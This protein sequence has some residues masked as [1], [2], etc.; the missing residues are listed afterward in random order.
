MQFVENA[1]TVEDLRDD[2]IRGDGFRR[3]D[4]FRRFGSLFVD[5]FCEF[6][7]DINED[8]NEDTSRSFFVGR[9]NIV[10]EGLKAIHWQSSNEVMRER[11]EDGVIV[12]IN[13]LFRRI[14]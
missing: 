10:K 2:F 1:S 9:V 11:T 3:R 6:N 14:I 7:E 5:L 12:T 13:I 4:A 8:I